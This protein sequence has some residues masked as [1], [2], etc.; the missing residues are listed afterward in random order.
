MLS[1]RSD[2]ARSAPEAA[3]R[4]SGTEAG[5]CPDAARARPQTLRRIRLIIET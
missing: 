2:R 1:L 3:P 4:I 5:K